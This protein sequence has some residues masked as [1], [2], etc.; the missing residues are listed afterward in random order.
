VAIATK[1]MAKDPAQRFQS[2]AEVAELLERCLAH[3]QSP[4]TVALPF[5]MTRLSGSLRTSPRRRAINRWAALVLPI[6]AGLFVVSE[7]TGATHIVKSLGTIL[8]FRTA[9]GTLVVEVD[10][11]AV[12]VS[13]DDKDLVITGAG[14]QEVRLKVGSHTVRATK[15]GQTKSEIVSIEKDG[16]ATVKVSFES[17]GPRAPIVDPNAGPSQPPFV[18]DFRQYTLQFQNEPWSAVFDGLTKLTGYPVTARTKPTGTF[19]FVSPKNEGGMLRRYKLAE[20]IDIVN[21]AL[22]QQHF[23]LVRRRER[24]I[25][26]PTDEKINPTYFE[27]VSSYELEQRGKTELV[28]Y[29]VRLEHVRG[30]DARAELQKLLSPI[31]MATTI[32]GGGISISDKAENVRRIVQVLTDLDRRGADAPNRFGGVGSDGR[33]PP[34]APPKVDERKFQIEFRDQPWGKIF[35][36]FGEQAKT[37]VI[38]NLKPAGTF[39][40]FPAREYTLGEFF[41][42]MND[43]LMQEKYLLVR[44]DKDFV[45]VR[46]DQKIDPSLYLQTAVAEL[47]RHS[48]SDLV[49]I[50]YRLGKM[51]AADAILAV[52]KMQSAMGGTVAEPVTNALLISDTAEHVRTIV[53]VLGEL[54]KGPRGGDLGGGAPGATIGDPAGGGGKG[55]LLK[56]K[57]PVFGLL[58]AD[59]PIALSLTDDGIEVWEVAASQS[60]IKLQFRVP[61]DDSREKSVTPKMAISSDG[62][63]AAYVVRD[64]LVVCDTTTGKRL[65]DATSHAGGIAAVAFGAHGKLIATAGATSR[66][67]RVWDTSTGNEVRQIAVEVG[68]ATVLAFSPDGTKLFAANHHIEI[69]AVT[70]GERIDVRDSMDGRVQ[71]AAFTPDG[72]VVALAGRTI[73]TW[74]PEKDAKVQRIETQIDLS[75]MALTSDGQRVLVGGRDGKLA[76]YRLVDGRLVRPSTVPGPVH[77]LS[78]SPDGQSYSVITETEDGRQLIGSSVANLSDSIFPPPVGR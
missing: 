30:M 69:F 65:K 43:S 40:L 62:K 23:L 7:G 52:Q 4:N 67:V 51:Q 9:E 60:R 10:D 26:M 14:A 11:P 74:K 56:P 32:P 6:L 15:D 31:G 44:R 57:S 47:P 21:D 41:D 78:I 50:V 48:R 25:V 61:T 37:P 46:T 34:P 38:N 63:L 72:N 58:A 28:N 13:L 73:L 3:V 42:L 22:M 16:K 8:R 64:T 2:A 76:L 36:W 53:R 35:D 27:N 45:V 19:T 55:A 1:L 66:V 77:A 33:L 75:A 18:K 20:V 71:A 17:D 54:E 49:S 5:V 24:F 29:I 12:K 70:T 39:S 68:P 59:A